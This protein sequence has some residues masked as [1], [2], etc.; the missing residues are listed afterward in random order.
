MMAPFACRRLW[1]FC[2]LHKKPRTFRSHFISCNAPRA[3]ARTRT[4]R[5]YSCRLVF[6][7]RLV[8]RTGLSILVRL[9]VPIVASHTCSTRRHLGARC[10]CRTSHRSRRIPSRILRRSIQHGTCSASHTVYSHICR[11]LSS[12]LDYL[13][14]TWYRP[15][16][17]SP[18]CCNHQ[19][20]YASRTQPGDCHITPESAAPSPRRGARDRSITF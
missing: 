3:R 9:G 14:S 6:P 11:R 1:H 19:P 10:T 12:P 7:P 4:G 8:G 16:N 15:R 18:R 20:S 17:N 5:R 2:R 13:A